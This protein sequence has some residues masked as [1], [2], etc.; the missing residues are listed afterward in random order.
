MHPDPLD[1][2]PR[3]AR[4]FS[5]RTA[6]LVAAGVV[7]FLAGALAQTYRQPR[8]AAPP[9]DRTPRYALLFYQ[10]PAAPGAPVDDVREMQEWAA[11]LRRLGHYVAGEHLAVGALEVERDTTWVAWAPGQVFGAP[12]LTGLFIVGAADEREIIAIA[13]SSPHVRRGGRIIVRPVDAL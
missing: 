6:N 8:G 5:W 10:R 3:P 2:A 13:Q 1:P 7:L 12:T 4:R 11:S 9:D